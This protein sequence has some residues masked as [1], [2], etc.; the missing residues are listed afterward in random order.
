MKLPTKSHGPKPTQAW[1][2]PKMMVASFQFPFK[3]TLKVSI[4]KTKT[5]PRAPKISRLK[6]LTQKPNLL[7]FVD[8]SIEPGYAL[9]IQV[10][11]EK[12]IRGLTS[13]PSRTSLGLCKSV[14][15]TWVCDFVCIC[16]IGQVEFSAN[17]VP[18]ANCNSRVPLQPTK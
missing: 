4:L 8:R 15:W 10:C 16:A 5:H 7:S 2:T 14:L 3:P 1:E 18:M 11:S 17:Y 12:D 6:H 13:T 9:H